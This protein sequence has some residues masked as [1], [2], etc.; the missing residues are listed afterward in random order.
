MRLPARDGSEP[1]EPHVDPPERGA[2]VDGDL[3]ARP[4]A[5][6]GRH[7]DSERDDR[8]A[9]GERDLRETFGS[10]HGGVLLTGFARTYRPRRTCAMDQSAAS[11][12]TAGRVSD[13]G[14]TRR[15]EG[16]ASGAAS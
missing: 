7:D 9:H 15:L 10:G 14:Q 8:R 11:M 1:L 12:K 6:A 13:A 4:G 2:D 5:R 16:G 3:G